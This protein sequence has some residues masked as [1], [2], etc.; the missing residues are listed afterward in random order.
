MMYVFPLLQAE[1]RLLP[2]DQ[3]FESLVL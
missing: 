2:I 3:L 1:R